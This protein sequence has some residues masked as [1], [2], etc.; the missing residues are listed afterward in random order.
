[1][2]NFYPP[3]FIKDEFEKKEYVETLIKS[4]STLEKNNNSWDKD[5]DLFF[6]QELD[7]VLKGI[8]FIFNEIRIEK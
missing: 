7:R 2:Y 6:Q 5:T 1:M 3:I 4:F 8:E